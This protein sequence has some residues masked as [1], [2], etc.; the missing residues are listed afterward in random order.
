MS[1]RN[2]PSRLVTGAKMSGGS[3]LRISV[4]AGMHA[5]EN[6]PCTLHLPAECGLEGPVDMVCPGSKRVVV[7]QVDRSS[8][9]PTLYFILDR[10]P[11]EHK[12]TYVLKPRR[13]ADCG[14]ELSDSG[15]VIEVKVCGAHFTSYHYA[16]VPAR[17]YLYP[18]LGPEGAHMTRAIQP[19]GTAGYDHPHHRSIWIAHGL[20]NGTDNWSEEAGHGRTV[21]RGFDLVSSGTVSGAIVESTEWVTEAGRKILDEKRSIRFWSQPDTC[22]CLDIAYTLRTGE[23]AVLFGDTKE[24]G[25]LSVRVNPEI[26]APA[27]LI[28]NSYGGLNEAETW[29]KRAHWCDYSGTIQ[30]VRAGI[31]VFDYPTNYGYPVHWHVRNYGLMTAN[32]FGISHFAPESGRRGDWVLGPHRSATFRYRVYIHAGD[33]R[34]GRVAERY[35]DFVN[36]PQCEVLS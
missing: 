20:V 27:G 25:M 16:D 32:P 28:A 23:D 36:P 19:R 6:T 2:T 5:R 15:T 31:A 17:P 12:R 35:H 11:A 18:V 26:N 34:A 1:T 29:G 8:E 4:S 30:G 33:A 24:G 3:M 13:H 14:V 9:G 10:L 22:R 21:H 7:G